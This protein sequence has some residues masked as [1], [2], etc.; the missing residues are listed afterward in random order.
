MSL[1]Y[2]FN[3]TYFIEEVKQLDENMKLLVFDNY[4]KFITAESTI[5]QMREKVEVMEEEM[6]RLSSNIERITMD[7]DSINDALQSKKKRIDM[8][9]GVHKLLQKVGEKY[10]SYEDTNIL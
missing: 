1:V 9:L 8:L 5:K 7:S 4:N 10:A 6:T 3:T 2:I